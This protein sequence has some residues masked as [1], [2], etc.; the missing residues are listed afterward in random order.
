[1]WKQ[2]H[3]RGFS[4]TGVFNDFGGSV[5]ERAGEGGGLLVGKVGE[6]CF[7][8]NE[9]EDQGDLHVKVD[10]DDVTAEVVGVVEDVLGPV[11]YVKRERKANVLE[12]LVDDAMVMMVDVIKDRANGNDSV[13]IGKLSLCEERAGERDRQCW[14][15]RDHQEGRSLPR[16]S[17]PFPLRL[18]AQLSIDK[19]KSRYCR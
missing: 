9:Q 14:G 19:A 8:K 17:L 1:M 10:D 4:M 6:F 3:S 2:S 15:G 18:E 12:V 11:K 13:V 7:V 16:R 5:A